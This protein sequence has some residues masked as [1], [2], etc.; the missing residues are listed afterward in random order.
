MDVS[1]ASMPLRI[2][3]WVVPVVRLR[4][5]LRVPMKVIYA[6]AAKGI[7]VGGRAHG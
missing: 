5:R 7:H 3:P 6:I 2:A 4:A 1:H